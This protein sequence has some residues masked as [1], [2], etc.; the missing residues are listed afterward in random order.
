MSIEIHSQHIYT[1]THIGHTNLHTDYIFSYI[2]Y[3]SIFFSNFM[4]IEHLTGVLILYG[5]IDDYVER[6]DKIGYLYINII[7]S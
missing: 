7:S 5:I 4:V 3:L 1:L 6:Q 2:L